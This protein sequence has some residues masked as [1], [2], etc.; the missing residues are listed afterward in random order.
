MVCTACVRPPL[1]GRRRWGVVVQYN[2]PSFSSNKEYNSVSRKLPFDVRLQ[3]QATLP[4]SPL[5]LAPSTEIKSYRV[6]G[7]E[8]AL[9]IVSLKGQREHTRA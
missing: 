8:S 6:E 2:V 1:G 9:T 3:Q 7:E 4:I 5:L